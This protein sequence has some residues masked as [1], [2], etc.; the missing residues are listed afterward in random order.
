[1]AMEFISHKLFNFKRLDLP[2]KFKDI[3]E[4]FAAGGS[5]QV[6]IDGAT[7]GVISFADGFT[8]E[9]NE[10]QAHNEKRYNEFKSFMLKSARYIDKAELSRI[11]NR[12]I[13]RGD[14]EPQWLDEVRKMA[15]AAPLEDETFSKT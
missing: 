10:T 6:L 5:L 13:G 3:S 1:M 4:C 2:A 9:Q 12:L 14:F 7:D 15:T 8:P 11:V